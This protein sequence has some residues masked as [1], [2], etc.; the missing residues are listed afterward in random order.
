M[1]RGGPKSA[2]SLG[3][4]G[5]PRRC[6]A[7]AAGPGPTL[8]H[9][10]TFVNLY[11]YFRPTADFGHRIAVSLAWGAGFVPEGQPAIALMGTPH[12][13][14]FLPPCRAAESL[15]SWLCYG[16]SSLRRG[17]NLRPDRACRQFLSAWGSQTTGKADRN[18]GA[19]WA[20][21]TPR[22][23]LFSA[24]SPTACLGTNQDRVAPRFPLAPLQLTGRVRVARRR[25]RAG[26]G[27]QAGMLTEVPGQE[28]VP[29]HAGVGLEDRAHRHPIL[30]RDVG[31]RFRRG[32]WCGSWAAALGE[33]CLVFRAAGKQL[34]E[35]KASSCL[36][37]GLF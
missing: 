3:R 34:V 1:S 32:R 8:L 15:C 26:A 36:R 27:F 9:L 23:V 31:D 33:R 11:L 30:Q 5:D 4:N 6:G 20:A 37:R 25:R 2:P 13:G 10:P 12:K 22:Y 21:V 14:H 18:G 16:S 35:K 29:I 28:M 24:T 17:K 19:P 7:A